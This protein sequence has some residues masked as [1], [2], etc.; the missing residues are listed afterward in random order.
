MNKALFEKQFAKGKPYEEIFISYLNTKDIILPPK[1]HKEYDVMSNGVKYEIKADY[2][3]HRTG[4]IAIE[5]E[6]FGKPSGI[7]TTTA[8]YW[9]IYTIAPNT[10]YDFYVIPIDI[11]R[12]IIKDKTMRRPNGINGLSWCHCIPKTKFA[13]H[14]VS[15]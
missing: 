4:N 12:E 13:K 11:I 14:L 9:V 6:Q 7:L 1:N 15:F 8:D 5:Y 2:V 10:S 3:C